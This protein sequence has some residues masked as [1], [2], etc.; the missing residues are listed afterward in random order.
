M[1]TLYIGFTIPHDI[2][3]FC[4]LPYKIAHKTQQIKNPGGGGGGGGG[5][6]EFQGGLQITLY[7]ILDQ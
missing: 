3:A 1:R 4:N 5:Y 2:K 7:S 6:M